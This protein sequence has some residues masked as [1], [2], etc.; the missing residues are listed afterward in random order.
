MKWLY[1]KRIKYAAKM[2]VT[3]FWISKLSGTPILDQK[4][5]SSRADKRN[6][7]EDIAMRHVTFR[8]L[9]VRLPVFPCCSTSTS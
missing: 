1:N 4:E 6:G 9:R 3:P 2:N 5:Q 8:V 7:F